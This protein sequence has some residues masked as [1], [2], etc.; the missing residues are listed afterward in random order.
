MLSN[1]PQNIL[2][3]QRNRIPG[4][5]LFLLSF[6]MCIYTN[7][8]SKKLIQI[9]DTWTTNDPCTTM[10]CSQQADGQV[11]RQEVILSCPP[12]TDCQEV[13]QWNPITLRRIETWHDFLFSIRAMNMSCQGRQS[14]A[15]NAYKRLVCWMENYTIS[16]HR[17][18]RIRALSILASVTEARWV[19]PPRLNTVTCW[20]VKIWNYLNVH[21]G[22][23]TGSYSRNASQVFPYRRLSREKLGRETG[24]VLRFLQC[25]TGSKYFT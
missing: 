6:K 16:D 20:V 8:Y 10:T 14:V 24:R 3:I 17:G 25:H 23:S 9:N 15:V 22:F 11:V 18:T 7:H 12:P 5:P 13:R 4:N 2:F 1:L 19:F 21:C